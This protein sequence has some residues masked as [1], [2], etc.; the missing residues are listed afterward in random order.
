LAEEGESE[1]EGER[2][3]HTVI[4]KLAKSKFYM[5]KGSEDLAAWEKRKQDSHLKEGDPVLIECDVRLLDWRKVGREQLQRHRQ[6]IDVILTDP[7]W[8][9]SLDLKYPVLQDHQIMAIPYNSCRQ[10]A[11]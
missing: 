7:L 10:T 8:Q 3:L 6:L 11:I 1:Q 2:L 5:V 4:T 9:I